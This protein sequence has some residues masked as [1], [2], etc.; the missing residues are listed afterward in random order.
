MKDKMS[1]DSLI[2]A[3]T[4]LIQ[5]PALVDVVLDHYTAPKEPVKV[6][7]KV[8]KKA[9]KKVYKISPTKQVRNKRILSGY[10]MGLKSSQIQKLV[11]V[12]YS[13]VQNVIALYAKKKAA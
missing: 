1:N 4:I 9:E 3:I 7:K 6:E 12:S 10:D 11:G 2:Q 8:V 5:N 13:T